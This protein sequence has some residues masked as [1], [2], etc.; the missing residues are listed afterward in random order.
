[1]NFMHIFLEQTTGSAGG[2]GLMGGMGGMLLMMVALLGVM[3]LFTIRPENK[4]KKE[5]ENMRNSIKVGDK[6]TTIGGLVG[7]ICHIKEDRVV[8]ET[9]ADR[10]RVEFLKSAI[11]SNDTANER[12]RAEAEKLAAARKREREERKAAK[13]KR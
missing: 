7:S 11:Q 9:G 6:V 2:G 5:A 1:M 4:R 12:A 10:V 8:I 3:Y 13:G